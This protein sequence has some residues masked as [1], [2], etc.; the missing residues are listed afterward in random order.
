MYNYSLK[1]KKMIE[2]KYDK[3]YINRDDKSIPKN[4]WAMA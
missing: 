4:S 1:A 3:K 2:W